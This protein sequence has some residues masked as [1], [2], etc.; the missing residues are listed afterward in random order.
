MDADVMLTIAFCFEVFLFALAAG[1]FVAHEARKSRSEAAAEKGRERLEPA[2]MRTPPGWS[3]STNLS[4]AA[5]ARP[6]TARAGRAVRDLRSVNPR[7]PVRN[8]GAKANVAFIFASIAAVL[9]VAALLTAVIIDP[10]ALGWVGFAIPAAVVVGLGAAATLLVPRMRV[11]PPRPGAAI[12]LSE[13][14]TAMEA[15]ETYT[16][17]LALLSAALLLVAAGL[18]KKQLVWKA[19]P[20]PMRRRRRRS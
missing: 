5:T 18:A 10:P 6:V 11:S 8:W 20:V 9:V 14:G 16:S 7:P 1:L 3:A 17:G 4:A 12:L 2:E 15:L 19:K 13:G